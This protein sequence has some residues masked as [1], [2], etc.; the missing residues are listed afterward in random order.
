MER[1]QNCIVFLRSKKMK[2]LRKASTEKENGVEELTEDQLAMKGKENS[3]SNSTLTNK[4]KNNSQNSLNSL[5]SI[6]SIKGEREDETIIDE[7]TKTKLSN[8]IT[9]NCLKD[10]QSGS[11]ELKEMPSPPPKKE[12]KNQNSK[13]DDLHPVANCKKRAGASSPSPSVGQFLPLL[14]V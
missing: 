11:G 8:D 12:L 13:K 4:M 7:E 3:G 5:N 14:L 6:D 10:S 1:I 9:N 2:E